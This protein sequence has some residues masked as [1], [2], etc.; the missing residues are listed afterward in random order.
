LLALSFL[1]TCRQYVGDPIDCIADGGIPRDVMDTY[2]WVQG[3]F[4]LPYPQKGGVSQSGVSSHTETEVKYHKYYHW[5][6]FILFFQA[7]S[8]YMPRYL[9]KTWEGGRIKMLAGNLNFPNASEG[10]KADQKKI[11]LD[12][13]A[14]HLHKHNLYAICF[15]ICEALNLLNV[16]GQTYFLDYFLDGEF[17]SYGLDV[18][19]FAGM[20]PED[21]VDPMS[22]IFP[23]LTKCTF[24]KFGHS[25]TVES[26]DALCVLSVN[27]V[28]EKIFLFLWFWFVALSLLTGLTLLYRAAVIVAPQI[29]L[30]LLRCRCDLASRDQIRAIHRKCQ[31]GD[32]FLLYWLSYNIEPLVYDELI[33]DLANRFEG[34]G[35]V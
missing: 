9:W 11:A 26:R 2:C 20:D 1:V 13:F 17:T 22:R 32:W 18:I 23:L 6:C 27:A 25:G 10:Y 29:R 8:F 7:I 35:T 15:I 30:Y 21:R 31:I 3:T 33:V 28:N 19:R 12:Y 4:T 34:K 14:T 5:V 16:V 24:L